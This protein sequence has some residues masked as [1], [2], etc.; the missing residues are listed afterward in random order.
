MVWC[1]LFILL[2]FTL[3]FILVIGE[4]VNITRC[5]YEGGTCFDGN[6]R[7]QYKGRGCKDETVDILL[8]RIDWTVKN[9]ENNPLYTTAYII[10]Y[11]VL[12]GIIFILYASSMY[13]LSPWEMI[14]LLF[15]IF[16]IVFSIL[17]LFNFHTNRYPLYY[18]RQNLIYISKKLK[19]N[20]VDPPKPCDKTGV[21]HRTHVRD[22][23]KY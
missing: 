2:L 17:N 4:N 7:Y 16:I 12:L 14:L 23:L 3:I 13:I 9:Y 5:P 8:D 15:G 18:M 10:S 20:I 19:L 1:Q 11:A 6:G 22:T 21:P